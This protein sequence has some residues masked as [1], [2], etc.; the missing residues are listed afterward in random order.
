MNVLRLTL[1]CVIQILIIRGKKH[2]ITYNL[3]KSPI[4]TIL[5]KMLLVI[6]ICLNME[7][8]VMDGHFDIISSAFN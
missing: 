6:I 4:K 1:S 7:Y 8:F 3:N 2:R 5:V